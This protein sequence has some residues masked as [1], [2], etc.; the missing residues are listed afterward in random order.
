MQILRA[1]V[2]VDGFFHRLAQASERILALDYDGTLAPF[3]VDRDQAFP[4]PGVIEALGSL[5]RGGHTRVVVVSGR[6]VEDLVS[7]LANLDPLPE[8][9]GGHGW[10]RRTLT[11][12]VRILPLPAGAEAGLKRARDWVEA[13]GILDRCECKPTGIAIHWR[14]LEAASITSLEKKV[15]SGF[16]SLTGNGCLELLRFDGGIELR[17]RGMDKGQV[18]DKLLSEVASDASVAYAGDDRTDEDAFRALGERGLRVLVRDQVR[19]TL[20]DV[21]LRP[22]G[23]LLDFLARWLRTA[24]GSP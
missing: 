22:P 10:E 7:L 4:F 14:G 24:G 2:D 18:I 8:I 23:E 5:M 1:S 9:W 21:W 3:R 11:G 16:S 6:P 13:E 12:E 15:H 19:P 17:A 20:A